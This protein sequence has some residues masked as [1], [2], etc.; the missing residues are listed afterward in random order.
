MTGIADWPLP[1]PTRPGA[2]PEGDTGATWPLIALAN[3]LPVVPTARGWRR[4]DGGLIVAVEAALRD[5]GGI[6]VGW[7][8][9][10]GP[11][12]TP[13]A[14]EG[15]DVR[16]IALD[17]AAID[18]SYNGFANR[19]L[20]PLLHGIVEQ[21]RF[22]PT[23]WPAYRR[24][25]ARFASVAARL[26][27]PDSVVWVHDYHLMLVPEMLRA[28]GVDAP[29]VMFL[30]VPFPALDVWARLPPGDPVLAG[31]LG[32]DV[33][34]FQT[35]GARD[36][37]AVACVT[38]GLARRHGADLLSTESGRW[39]RIRVD[40]I[41]V[42]AEAIAE[43]ATSP[44]TRAVEAVLTHRNGRRT[45]L[46]GVDR[47]DYTKGIAERLRAF[48]LLLER[49]SDLRGAVVLTQVA[50]P[51]RMDVA[52]NEDVR[53]EVD[54]LVGRINGRFTPVGGEPPVTYI[55]RPVNDAELLALYAT[56]DVAWVTPLRDG[57]NLVA[58]EYVVAQRSRGG[59]GVL[60]LSRFAGAAEELADAIQCDPHD[61]AAMADAIEAALAMPET[62]RRARL[63][64]MAR[65]VT[66]YDVHHWA[67]RQIPAIPPVY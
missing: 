5:R 22:D 16:P 57:M 9:S 27:G 67:R 34:G 28:A 58:K 61:L 49:R 10:A 17:A 66:T 44:A 21:Y 2:V 39:V 6:W 12:G 41:S 50:V 60:V 38:A 15:Y 31:M 56:S 62:E 14:G 53:R 8:G 63:A 30:H 45:T 48:E 3:R 65:Q 20:W 36:N 51:T 47:L 11:A 33:I 35:A 32:S 64:S 4:A 19:A 24:V 29:V 55:R 18:G 42:D 46:L 26:A 25:N 52:E 1:A 7:D 43:R 54:E 13:P 59:S 40:P 37:F 23:W